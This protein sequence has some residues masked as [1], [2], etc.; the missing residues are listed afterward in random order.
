MTVRANDREM[1]KVVAQKPMDRHDKKALI[2]IPLLAAGGLLILPLLP[3]KPVSSFETLQ[4]NGNVKVISPQKAI[5]ENPTRGSE[6]VPGSIIQT[7]PESEIDLEIPGQVKMRIKE[8]S[9]VV[10]GKAYFYEKQPPLRVL[11]ESGRVLATR[12][13]NATLQNFE[14]KTNAFSAHFITDSRGSAALNI[15]AVDNIDRVSVIRGQAEVQKAGFLSNSKMLLSPLEKIESI[16][17]QK[18]S[19]PQEVSREEWDKMKEI[20][21]LTQKSAAQ[22]AKQLDLARKAGSFFEYVFDHG[23]FYTPKFGY[24]ERGFFMQ[25]DGQSSYV[26]IE[27]DVF[28]PGSYAGVYVKT[29]DLD[30]SKF[31]AFEFDIRKVEGE[32]FPVNVRVELKSKSGLV[33]AFALKNPGEGWEKR[34]FPLLFKKE[35]LLTEVA[36]VFHN[37]MVGENK[38]GMIEFR[39]VNLVP[40][41]AEELAKMKAAVSG[42]KKSTAALPPIS[43]ETKV[44]EPRAVFVQTQEVPTGGNS[45]A[46]TF[47]P[48]T[49]PVSP[50]DVPTIKKVTL[51]SIPEKEST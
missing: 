14:L 8:N 10:V 9:E 38:K 47:A 51:E 7:G 6:I 49:T 46:T 44:S 35:T 5:L 22:E 25:E 28:P 41:T 32:G 33:R 15:E 29:R 16:K 24:C 13:K 36:V 3:V 4:T 2:I 1:K 40:K 31:S 30:V 37:T 12:E 18:A 20:Y 27:Y 34:T 19:A 50:A 11:I 23:S 42:E 45:S 39:N 43:T 21:E 26:Q 17:G 48:K